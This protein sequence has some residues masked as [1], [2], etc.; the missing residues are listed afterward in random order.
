MHVEP[1]KISALMDKPKNREECYIVID[2][3]IEA[4]EGFMA[5]MK[6][7]EGTRAYNLVELSYRE[8]LKELRKMLKL[9]KF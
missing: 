9:N 1:K 2:K 4:L 8:R 7:K 6:H 5:K 3:T